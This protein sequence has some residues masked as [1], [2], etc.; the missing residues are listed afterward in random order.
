MPLIRSRAPTKFA[1][2]LLCGLP[3]VMT[4]GIG[5]F[6][7]L[8]KKENLG[9]VLGGNHWS[10]DLHA[11]WGELNSLSDPIRREQIA[12]LGKQMFSNE[13]F[14][15]VLTPLYSTLFEG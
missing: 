9:I 10:E 7:Q 5:D 15:N 2:Y 11:Q 8:A 4:A 13:H 1:E 3:V 12:Q 14:A 6:S